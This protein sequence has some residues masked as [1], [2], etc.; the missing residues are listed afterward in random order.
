MQYW[1]KR[2]ESRDQWKCDTFIKL[3]QNRIAA[4]NVCHSKPQQA[5]SRNK[6]RIYHWNADGTRQEFLNSRIYLSFL[7]L[8]FWLSRS[9]RLSI[10]RLQ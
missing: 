1:S 4:F 7:T 3:Q 8:M 6:L 10:K 2:F 5:A 9:L